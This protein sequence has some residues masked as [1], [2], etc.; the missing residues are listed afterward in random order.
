[1]MDITIY[2]T[3]TCS[4]CHALSKWLDEQKMVYKKIVTDQDPEGMAEFMSVN[5]GMISVPLTIIKD[6]TGN[7]TK[8]S[9]FDKEK[10]KQVLGV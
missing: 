8:I 6:Q 2:S 1:M 10:F 4:Y 3:S 7:E 9:G 5:D